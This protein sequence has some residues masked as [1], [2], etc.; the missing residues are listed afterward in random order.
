MRS[1]VMS[2][3]MVLA[4]TAALADSSTAPAP[5]APAAPGSGILGAP[6]TPAEIDQARQYADCMSLADSA[7]DKALAKAKAWQRKDGG[8]PA[9]HCAAV[10]L[11]GLGRYKEAASAMEKLAVEELKENKRSRRR[12]YGQAAQ[13]WVL[14]HRQCP[15]HQG[16]RR[17]SA[18]R[19]TI[20]IC[21]STA[22]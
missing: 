2:I 12:L 19:R 15:R 6:A 20:P 11:V 18:W 7:P 17:R 14:Y 5:T 10:A 16:R 3:A 13:A 21:W 8:A 22:A 9:G 4:A 1:T